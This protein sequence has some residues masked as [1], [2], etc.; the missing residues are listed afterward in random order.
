MKYLKKS[1]PLL[2]LAIGLF[3]LSACGEEKQTEQKNVEPTTASAEEEAPANQTAEKN[4]AIYTPSDWLEEG[5]QIVSTTFATLSSHLKSALQKGGVQ[6]A[7]Q[8]C[9]L[10][11]YPL[12]DSLSRVHNASIRRVSLKVRNPKDLP[13]RLEERALKRAQTMLAKG[14]TIEPWV[15]HYP[16]ETAYYAPIYVR[17]VCLKCHGMPGQ[18][19]ASEDYAFIRK[20]YPEDQ[21]TGYR[22][23]DWRGLWSIRFR[24]E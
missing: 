16:E 18:T 17:D 14:K 13:D 6:E 21:A 20:L 10:N 5:G 8:Y 1:F 7:V 4:R 9:H 11:A 24:R 2:L 22:E 3:F 19:I 15:E 23:G 12:V